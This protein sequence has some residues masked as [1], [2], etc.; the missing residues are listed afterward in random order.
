MT[1][2]GYGSRRARS[3]SWGGAEP[4]IGRAFARP[5][6]ADPL[7]WPGL[8]NFSRL[9]QRLLQILDQIVV[10]FEAGRES[11]KS[12]ADAE[13]GSN[14]RRQPLMRRGGRMGDEALGV[15]EIVGNPRDLQRV[16]ATERRRLAAFDL[17][18][19][20]GR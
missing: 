2:C 10:M 19:D 18:A 17:E 7:A 14:L 1:P 5:V 13:F 16:E 4:V 6:G 15:A 3:L 20:Q 11:D 8:L 9:L 12:F